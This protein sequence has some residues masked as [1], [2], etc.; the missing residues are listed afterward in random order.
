M[1]QE[2]LFNGVFPILFGEGDGLIIAAKKVLLDQFVISPFLCLPMAYIIKAIVFRQSVSDG[3]QSYIYDVKN[4][5]LLTKYWL[6]WFPVQCLTFT[7]VPTQ[8]RITF[9]ACFSFFWLILLSKIAG[10]SDRTI[11]VCEEESS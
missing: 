8:F 11:S 5:S 9:I 3:V 2:F 1:F 10:K 4:N 6:V 7:V